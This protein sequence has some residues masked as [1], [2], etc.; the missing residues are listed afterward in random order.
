MT[1]PAWPV[2]TV[3]F[4]FTDVEGSTQLWERQTAEMREALRRHD[5]LLRE[6]I[7]S[8][9]GVVFKTIG[10]AFCA[11]FADADAALAAAIAVQ[12]TLRREVPELRVRAAL[13]IGEPE[14][15]D[16]DYFGH[17][18]SRV[19]R[20]TTAGHGGQVLLTQAMAERIR[21]TLP[22]EVQLHSL[23]VHRLRDLAA[24]EAIYQLQIP[25]LPAD[26]PPLNSLDVAFRRGLR[27]A[28]AV[29]AL[30]VAAL[31]GLL[32]QSIHE[33]RRADRSAEQTLRLLTQSQVD[34]GV[35]RLEDG[36]GLGLLDLLQARQTAETLP[37]LKEA[38]STVWAGWHQSYAGRLINAVG[39]DGAIL[40]M[41]FSPDGRRLATASD[42]K[43]V[44]LWDTH[45]W[46][47]AARPLVHDAPVRI[48]KFSPDGRR[49][50]TAAGNRVRLWDTATGKPRGRP[51]PH[52]ED[53]GTMA[54]SPDG[55]LLA[56]VAGD[57]VLLWDTS[58]GQPHGPPL[59]QSA[60]GVFIGFEPAPG[61]LLVAATAHEVSLWN[62]ATG[63]RVGILFKQNGSASYTP[64]LSLSRDGVVRAVVGI[65]AAWKWDA[66]TREYRRTRLPPLGPLEWATLSPDGRLL[67]TAATYGAGTSWSEPT[68]Q[69]WNTETGERSV[70]PLRHPG[71]VNALEF[72]PL[73]TH[74]IVTLCQGMVRY[75]DTTTGQPSPEPGPPPGMAT[76]ALLAVSPDGRSVATVPARG[77][78]QL[79]SLATPRPDR[80]LSLASGA[81]SMA[82]LNDSPVLATYSDRD[83]RNGLRLWS[84]DTGQLL[85]R[86]AGIPGKCAGAFGPD[87][88][89][90]VQWH[91]RTVWEWET[92]TGGRRGPPL[93][94]PRRVRFAASSSRRSILAVL[95]PVDTVQ[96]LD[97]TRGPRS[98]VL[99]H[100]PSTVGNLQ[101]SPDGSLLATATGDGIR[102]WETATGHLRAPPVQFRGT[103]RWLSFSPAGSGPCARNR[104]HTSGHGNRK[105][106]PA[107]PL[108]PR[109][110]GPGGVQPRRDTTGHR[111]RRQR[112]TDLG[113]GERARLRPDDAPPGYR[114]R[115]PI[116]PGRAPP[117]VRFVQRG[118]ALGGDHRAACRPAM[119]R[120]RAGVGRPLRPVRSAP[121]R[122][123]GPGCLLAA[124]ARN[125]Y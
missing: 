31:A 110:G 108:A 61:G 60:N 99:L 111:H 73:G 33:R 82:F 45:T 120:P 91:D 1:T 41:A 88:Q 8:H 77:T 79:W 53:V 62:P 94:F 100:H 85:G 115:R 22:E 40:D 76:Q 118:A 66:T 117:G 9:G 81:L 43:T 15:R 56:T 57:R 50:A 86:P 75:W 74:L 64:I 46:E 38:V 7:Q 35:K 2:G 55:K 58:T 87:G 39:H 16:Q 28:L 17:E 72:G 3:A 103:P 93:E 59:R 124:T 113:S 102:L 121:R 48:V 21:G 63:I 70:S 116:Q 5:R 24:P 25:G 54:Y 90:L 92:R 29:A 98:A 106:L 20:L 107:P 42:D 23:G 12:H 49:L 78:V 125:T 4:L 109:N 36:D 69:L 51:M 89:T 65:R 119:G 27:R 104:C 97:P 19:A 80:R 34:Q 52:G 37:D 30:V 96:L 10:D 112:S 6:V 95:S 71:S 18:L 13:H 67:A 26:F 47:L 122:A 101:F 11:A 105:S 83:V 114:S 68:V 32:L 84:T 14:F 123:D 44:K